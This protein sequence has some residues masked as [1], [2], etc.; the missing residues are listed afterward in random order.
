MNENVFGVSDDYNNMPVN[1]FEGL[2]PSQMHELL[3]GDIGTGIVKIR[4]ILKKKKMK[5]RY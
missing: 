1:D 5:F 3:Y 2:S 4:L